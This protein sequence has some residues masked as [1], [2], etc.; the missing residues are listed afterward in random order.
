MSFED[1]DKSENNH[2]FDGDLYY[3]VEEVKRFCHD[4][5]NC[6]NDLNNIGRAQEIAR[7]T[8]AKYS[9]L[10]LTFCGEKF[11]SKKKV[12]EAIDKLKD[13]GTFG[14]SC[15]DNLLKELGLESD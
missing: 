10:E 13:D 15:S 5:K 6:P 14:R 11:I 3:L 7:Q 4:N 1:L 9:E 8:M 2:T 12:R